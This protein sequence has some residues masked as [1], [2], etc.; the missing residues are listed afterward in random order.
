MKIASAAAV[1]K[2]ALIILFGQVA[3]AGAADIKL[4]T[5][6]GLKPVLEELGPEFERKTGQKL[7]IEYASTFSSKRKIEAGEPF[8]VAILG[9]PQVVDELV[10]QGKLTVRTIIAR[11][12]IGVAV[13]EGAPKPAIDSADAFKRALLNA[14][15]VA[16]NSDGATAKHMEHVFERLGIANEMKPKMKPQPGAERAIQSVVAGDAELGILVSSSILSTRGA[17]LAGL[18]PRE[19]QEYVVYTAG[20][21]SATKEPKGSKE[22]IDF[23]LSE[24]ATPV[25]KANGLER[26]VH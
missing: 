9:T 24:R 10:K 14:K 20:V 2:I 1:G 5:G 4:L 21:S 19:L 8:D 12:G 23:L 15:S 7:L 3:L 13:R 6:S 18:L 26:P 22:L 25:M 11:S 16:Y 17:Q